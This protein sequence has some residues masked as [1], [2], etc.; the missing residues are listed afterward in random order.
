M[1]FL[2]E[3]GSLNEFLEWLTLKNN[4]INDFIWIKIGLYLLIGVVVLSP[5][6]MKITKN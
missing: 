4:E 5:V 3:E 6:V 2:R 1:N